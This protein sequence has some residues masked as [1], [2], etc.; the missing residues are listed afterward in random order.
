M[1]RGLKRFFLLGM[2]IAAAGAAAKAASDDAIITQTAANSKNRRH[3][4][5]AFNSI[6]NFEKFIYTSFIFK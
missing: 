2:G 1:K 4:R 5:S 6:W 3:A